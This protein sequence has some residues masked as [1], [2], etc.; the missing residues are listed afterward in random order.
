MSSVRLIQT[1][2]VF[3]IC[4]IA[5]G[6]T[7]I[8]D[9]FQSSQRRIALSLGRNSKNI[10]RRL[11][12]SL[13]SSVSKDKSESTAST[14]RV[15]NAAALI[16][17][18]EHVAALENHARMGIAN[19]PAAHTEYDQSN[20]SSPNAEHETPPESL[21]SPPPV[22][23]ANPAAAK[24]KGPV[25]TVESVEELLAAMDCQGNT[26]DNTNESDMTLILFHAHYCKICQRATMQ[27]TKA[28]REY[29][30]VNFAKAEAK[31]IPEPAA[32]NLR[33]L[34]ISKFPFVQIYRRGACVASFSTG[35]TH[36]FMRKIRGTLD[37]CL[38][39]DED[40][41]DNFSKD[42]A[43]EI[44]GNRDAREQLRPELT[45]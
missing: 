35:P 45:P 33:T 26:N 22:K 36:M 6:R 24:R 5:I 17:G 3:C 14:V 31:V 25:T 32:D 9:A 12:L 16:N 2:K 43:A 38:E 20:L 7:G 37:L 8:A 29:P 1:L 4:L 18:P 27:M 42:F 39:R 34:G 23:R 41:W 15:V 44:Q 28:A 11:P 30:S 21:T 40:C 10:D 19:G 13:S